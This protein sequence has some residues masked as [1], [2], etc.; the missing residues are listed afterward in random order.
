MKLEVALDVEAGIEKCPTGIAG[1]DEILRGGL[2]AGRP[3]LICGGPGCGKTTLAMEFLVRGAREFDEPGLF[4]SFEE[5]TQE[6]IDNFRSLGFDLEDLIESKKLKIVQVGISKEEIVETGSFSLDGLIVQLEYGIAAIGAKRVVLDTLESLLSTLSQTDMLRTEISRLL[7]WLR[8]KGVASIVT[9]ERG[10]EELTR[11]GF[12][13]YLSDCVILLD[14]RISEQTSKRRLRI[15]KYR[16]SRHAA[17]EFPFM[18]AQ[19]GFSVLPITS[20]SLDYGASMERVSSGIEG[21]DEMLGGEGYFKATTVL[22]TG[23]SG[24][25]KSSLAAAFA[26]ASCERGERCLYF[27]LE[28]SA[29]QII[30]NMLSLGIDL[31]KWVDSGALTIQA[32][33]PSFRGLEEH[34]LSMADV[35]NR[36]KPTC[37][38]MDPA[39]NFGTSGAAEEVKS[40]LTRIL[41]IFKRQ[42]CTLFMTGVTADTSEAKVAEVHISALV[43]DTWLTLEVERMPSYSRRTLHI[44]K[45]RGMEHSTDTRELVMSSH[46]FALHSLTDSVERLGVL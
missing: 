16:G 34:L 18:I 1:L 23:G 12:E 11:H 31:Q 21:I 30:R 10:K 9:G 29:A 35:T 7:H 22:V 17:D 20:L 38:V 24:A 37:V 41:D 42:G 36:V 5:S 6:L 8:D 25:G 28:E 43:V 40:M 4:I 27:A 3:T 26:D 33:R 32:F 45:S 13:E 39:T 14:H 2:P 46:G 15:V 19:R 44:V